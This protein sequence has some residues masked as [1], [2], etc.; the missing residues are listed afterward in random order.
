MTLARESSLIAILAGGT[1]AARL[2]RGLV[3]VADPVGLTAIV[4]TAD[5]FV[6][7]GLR[8]SPDIDTVRFT[9]SDDIGEL[10]WGR[11]DETWRSMRELREL[12]RHAP[13]GSRASDW[14]RLGDRDLAIHL[15]RTQRMSEGASLCEVTSELAD[16][17]GVRVAM[18][19]ATENEVATKLTLASGEEVDFQDYFVR[20][21]HS[22]AI[23][24]VRF[25]GIDVAEP[26]PGVLEALEEAERI[27]VA[28][29]N[30]FVSIG[31]ILSIRGI[32]EVMERRRDRVIAVSPIVNGQAIKGPAGRMFTELGIEPDVT[33]VARLW[34]S[35]ASVLVVDQSDAR[36]CGAIAALGME[37]VVLPTIM[38]DLSA[39]SSL[40]KNL[41]DV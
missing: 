26:A 11:A 31:P 21:Q 4:N 1:G 18:L 7:H 24:S 12:S 23:R 40:A 6:L 39:S 9:L 36:A 10:G 19:P 28:P 17:A 15:Y 32:R 22:V 8:I 13:A 16:A 37:P 41:L 33:S 5:D 30:P 27:V 3:E 35:I 25:A 38:H 20:R 34:S 2:L 29:S 14:F